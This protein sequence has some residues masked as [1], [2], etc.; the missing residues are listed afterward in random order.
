MAG[1]PLVDQGTLNRLRGSITWSSNPSLNITAPYLGREGISLSLT[2]EA[3]QFFPTLTGTST[4]PEPYQMIEVTVHLLKTQSFADL[5]KKQMEAS[6]LLGNGVVW[7]DTTTLS[8]Y[9]ILNCGIKSVRELPFNGTSPEWV[10][11]IGGYYL[12]NSSLWNL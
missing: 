9:E 11:T 5:Y 4:S 3:T 2:G 6:S 12:V 1:N 8:T 10:V 7:P